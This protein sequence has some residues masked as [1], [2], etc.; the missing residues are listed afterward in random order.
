[1]LRPANDIIIRRVFTEHI[2]VAFTLSTT[3]SAQLPSALLPLNPLHRT[4]NALPLALNSAGRRRYHHKNKGTVSSYCPLTSIPNLLLSP[5]FPAPAEESLFSQAFF[6]PVTSA[7]IVVNF[8]EQRVD[9][10]RMS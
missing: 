10:V 4:R 1:M 8:R 9:R 2:D 3:A 7:S 6:L 5:N